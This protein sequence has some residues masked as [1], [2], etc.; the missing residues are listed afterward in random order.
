MIAIRVHPE[1]EFSDPSFPPGCR[2]GSHGGGPRQSE[3]P[4]TASTSPTTDTDDR[5]HPPFPLSRAREWRVSENGLA[6]AVAKDVAS[7]TPRDITGDTAC[8]NDRS[9]GSLGVERIHRLSVSDGTGPTATSTATSTACQSRDRGY[10]LLFL[11]SLKEAASSR[12][13]IAELPARCISGNAAR[14]QRGCQAAD[15]AFCRVV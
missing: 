12:H 2:V 6:Q 10:V 14:R 5:P 13:G 8:D 3:P 15:G 9:T 4:T 7:P 11:R 1:L